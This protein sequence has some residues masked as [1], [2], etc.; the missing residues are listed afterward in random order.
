M[1]A[2]VS[3]ILWAQQTGVV[4]IDVADAVK[5]PEEKTSPRQMTDKEEADLVAAV[6]QHGSLRDR[7]IIFLMLHTGLRTMEV[8][9]LK[10]EDVTIG[11]RSG[12][13]VVRFGKKQT[14]GVAA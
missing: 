6:Q 10:P 8:C 4:K 3:D 12:T 5:L 1:S 14:A 13:L 11:K 7:T 2:K 9:N